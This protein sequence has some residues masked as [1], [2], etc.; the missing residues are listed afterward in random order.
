MTSVDSSE[1]ASR[2]GPGGAWGSLLSAQDFAA[3]TSAGFSPVGH[4]LGTSVVHLGYASR[5]GRCSTNG[6]YTAR[7]DLASATSGPFERLLRQRYAVRHR[8][9]SRA[10]EQCRDLGGDGIVGVTLQI[11]PFPAGGTEFTVQGTAVRART[12]AGAHPAEPFSSHLSAP[13]FARLLRADWMPAAMVF[14]I[15]LGARHDDTRTRSQTQRT[16]N[17]EVK[18]YTQ[19]VRD[20]RRDARKQLEKAVAEH[21]A[22]GVVVAAM[23]LHIGDRECP[24]EQGRDH[25][26]EAA[27]VGTAIAA[28]SRAEAADDRPPLVIMRVNPSRAAAAA[29]DGLPGMRH[30]GARP[31]S[32]SAAGE[33]AP[34]AEPG[35]EGGV[36]DRLASSRAA[37]RASRNSLSYSDPSGISKK[38]D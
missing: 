19:L 31:A 13:E 25:V 3:V 11:R 16:A 32:A 8:A 29:G 33:P 2:G 37:K 30:D 6:S 35:S 12:M 34:E 9:L 5:G 7:T 10:L 20:T 26:A 1:T 21:G 22:D 23:T 4:V 27:I 14:G 17:G 28:F 15:A 18:G 36:L 38:T 24:A